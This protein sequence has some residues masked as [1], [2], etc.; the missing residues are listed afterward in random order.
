MLRIKMTVLVIVFIA[1]AILFHGGPSTAGDS[2]IDQE[3]AATLAQFGFTGRIESTLEARLGR[4]VNEGFA[5]LGRLL[6]Y[7]AIVGVNDDNACAGCHAPT[8]GYADTQSIA[9]GIESNG[10]VGP[11]RSGPRNRR[12]SP[13]TI[14]AAFYPNMM[15]NS[16]FVS[17]ADDPF[18]NRAG[19]QFPEPEGLSLSRLP[20]LLAAQAFMPAADRAEMA[21]F[22]FPGDNFAIRDEIARRVNGIA[23]Y[24]KRFGKFFPEVKAGAPITYDMIAQ[25]VAEFE[26]TLVFA[27]APIDRFARGSTGAMSNDQKRGALLFF[28]KARCVECHAVSGRSNE[29]FS[30]FTPRVIGV[31]QIVPSNTNVTFD[32]PAANEDYGLEN[33]TGDPLDRYKFRTAP[34][35][36][37]TFQPSFFHNGA[38]TSLKD[39]IRHHLD[40]FKSARGYDPGEAGLDRDLTGPTGPIEPVLERV[41]PLLASPINLTEEEFRDLVA[42]VRDGLADDRAGPDNLR[43]LVPKKVPSR[44]HVFTF[45]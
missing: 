22:R 9:I 42:F 43:K 21:G 6:F 14:N 30:D 13:T 39:A 15:W 33:L 20:H 31:P 41:D 25:A 4:P 36:N 1:S 40:V 8:T 37:V 28:G 19:F 16:R 35:R 44:R 29:M 38:F 34:L 5:D 18:D 12:R 10:L 45:E 24:R 7:D 23:K 17:L 26:F 32:G 2:S 11:S 27:N 3:L